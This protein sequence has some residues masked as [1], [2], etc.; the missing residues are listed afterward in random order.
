MDEPQ[1]VNGSDLRSLLRFLWIAWPIGAAVVLAVFGRGRHGT[2]AAILVFSAV[3]VFA[4][5]SHTLSQN[6]AADEPHLRS[7][8]GATSVLTGLI[9]LALWV[10]F[11]FVYVMFE[12]FYE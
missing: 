8:Q 7:V 12:S 1:S 5:L 11:V 3:V 4:W 2:L 10:P 9:G 6:A